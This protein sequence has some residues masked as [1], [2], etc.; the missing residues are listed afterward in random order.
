MTPRKFDID[1]LHVAAPCPVPWETMKGDNRKR[2]CDMC[3]LNV[4]NISEMTHAEAES[5]LANAEGRICG[6]TT[7]G[8]TAR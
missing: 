6:K 5:L 3:S 2:F 1:K 7:A 4:Y 8:P